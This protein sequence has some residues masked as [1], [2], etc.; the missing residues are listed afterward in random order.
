MFDKLFE[1]DHVIAKH[2]NGP[3]ATERENFL[4]HLEAK[5]Y[6]RRV[7]RETAITLMVVVRRMGVVSPRT[8]TWEEIESAAQSWAKS[9]T[10]RKRARSIYYP[11][12]MFRR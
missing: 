1:R 12:R 10:L 5:K 6:A 2:R 9:Q 3:L 4:R 8:I 7:I 11:K